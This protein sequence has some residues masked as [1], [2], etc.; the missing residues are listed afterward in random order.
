MN[1][2]I[3]RFNLFCLGSRFDVNKMLEI[4][5]F[6]MCTHLKLIYDD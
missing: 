6:N 5:N 1:F 2:Y 3:L 4:Y